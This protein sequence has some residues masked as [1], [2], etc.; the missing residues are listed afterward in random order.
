MRIEI[1][2]NHENPEPFQ[3]YCEMQKLKN[4][5]VRSLPSDESDCTLSLYNI[6]PRRRS[7]MFN[8]HCTM[9]VRWRDTFYV[10]RFSSVEYNVWTTYIYKSDI[11]LLIETA[12]RSLFIV[13]Y[14]IEEAELDVDS[15]CFIPT[16]GPTVQWNSLYGSTHFEILD[17]EK[18][19]IERKGNFINYFILYRGTYVP[20]FLHFRQV[21]S[22][23]RN[24]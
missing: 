24:L 15:G 3:P 19:G 14:W 1:E 21:S 13:I 10:H 7:Y 5:N 22:Y 17:R 9:Y 20:T 2:S 18:G 4:N 11:S 12:P 16:I 23:I 6:T 8:V